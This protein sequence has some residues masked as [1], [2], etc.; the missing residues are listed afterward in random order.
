M[1]SLERKIVTVKENM[2]VEFEKERATW[3]REKAEL[4]QEQ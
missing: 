2:A 1:A 3:G 4:L